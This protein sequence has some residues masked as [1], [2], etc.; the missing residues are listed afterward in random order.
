MVSIDTVGSSE[1][2]LKS[3]GFPTLEVHKSFS[4][5]DFTRPGRRVLLIGPMGSG[6][7]EFAARVWRDA[8]IAQRKGD[9]VRTLTSTG[10]V[11]RRN[12]FFIRSQLDGAR[13]LR[14]LDCEE[15]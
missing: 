4:H 8:S 11:D 7:T 15:R 9:K 3:L 12:V 5:F 2:F 1:D 13:F 6:K 14:S 10:D